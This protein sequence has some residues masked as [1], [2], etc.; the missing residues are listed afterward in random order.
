MDIVYSKMFL[1]LRFPLWLLEYMGGSMFNFQVFG[2][3][4]GG[5]FVLIFFNSN[6]LWSEKNIFCIIFSFLNCL[7]R[8]VLWP[9]APFV[10]GFVCTWMSILLVG[11]FWK[12]QL[13]LVDGIV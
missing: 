4:G 5:L 7:L 2:D 12:C 10:N 11:V 3:F 8:F 6:S 9:I 13:D 1:T